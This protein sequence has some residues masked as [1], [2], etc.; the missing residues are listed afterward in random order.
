MK[1]D[2]LDEIELAL[3]QAHD[4][5]R[6]ARRVRDELGG[7]HRNVLHVVKSTVKGAIRSAQAEIEE[8][9]KG[10]TL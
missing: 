5:V 1:T 4:Q 6:R 10:R 3:L 2:R 9:A 7:D 8:L